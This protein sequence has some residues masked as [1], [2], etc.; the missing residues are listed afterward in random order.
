MK[1]RVAVFGVGPSGL[2]AGH[3][4]TLLGLDV[5][6]FSAEIAPSTLHGCQYL[7][8]EIPNVK[9]RSEV[10]EY[11]LRGTVEGYRRKVYGAGWGGPVSPEKMQG[12]RQAW[13]LRMAYGDL[14]ERYI[15]P[16]YNA[17]PFVVSAETLGRTIDRFN[18]RFDML[19][20]TVPGKAICY[21]PDVHE[22]RT[23]D[24]YAIGDRI[25]EAGYSPLGDIDNFVICDGSDL[26]SWY[27]SA[28]VFGMSTTEWSTIGKV[29]PPIEGVKKI[30]KPLTTNCNC[31]PN[32]NRLG[33][34]GAWRKSVLTHDVF[35]LAHNLMVTEF[36]APPMRVYN[37]P[38]ECK[39][40]YRPACAERYALEIDAMEYTCLSGHRWNS[41][42]P[43]KT[44]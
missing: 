6:F 33:R 25:E 13:D 1:P 37:R 18:D 2:M 31:F 12:E 28:R 44:A 17:H 32:I 9:T 22:F 27:R 23:R 24:V 21:R 36:G 10:V 8:G 11:R 20:S 4:A 43:E 39:R 29:R 30:S 7:H 41:K 26:F 19:I 15:R 5:E 40:C 3:A 35:E 16:G 14:F 34:Y 42:R 38:D